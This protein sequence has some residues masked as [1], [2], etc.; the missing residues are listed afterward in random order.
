MP[1]ETAVA[2]IKAHGGEYVSAMSGK[3]TRLLAGTKLEDGRPVE[4]SSKYQDFIKRCAEGKADLVKFT[5]GEFREFLANSLPKKKEEPVTSP[6]AAA[7][8]AA[9][10]AGSSFV[11]P[12][13][14]TGGAGSAAS[15]SSSSSSG[16]AANAAAAEASSSAGAAAVDSSSSLWVDRYKPR[17]FQDLAGNPKGVQALDVWLTQWEAKHLK[18]KDEGG[19]DDSDDEEGGAGAGGKK[20]KA[21]GPP[22]PKGVFDF[23]TREASGGPDARAALISGPPG[24]GKT[25]TAILLAKRHGYEVME[26]NASDTRTKK[27]LDEVLKGALDSNVLRFDSAFGG[28]PASQ[29]ATSKR[30]LVVMDEVDGMGI[31]DRGGNAEIAKFL[32]ETKVPI[33]CICNDRQKNSVKT[34]A[35][36][37]YD[38]KF[39]P[40]SIE[41]VK[42]RLRVVTQAEGMT[43]DDTALTQLIESVNGDLRQ[44]LN[45]LHMWALTEKTMSSTGFSAR[46]GAL[47]KDWLHRYDA[48]SAYPRLFNTQNNKLWERDELFFVDY[49]M[50][51]FLIQQAYPTVLES[52]KVLNENV[53]L[54]RMAASA[55]AVSE[56]DIYYDYL[57]SKQAWQLLPSCAMANIRA[58]GFAAGGTCPYI[59]FPAYWGKMSSRT[60]RAR[61]LAELGSHMNSKISGGRSAV[62][63]DYLSPLKH[64]FFTPL[65]RTANGG[66]TNAITKGVADLLDEYNLT[67]EDLMVTLGEELIFKPDQLGLPMNA[68]AEPEFSDFLKAIPAQTKAAFTRMWNS[69]PHRTQVY[70]GLAPGK[71]SAFLGKKV[72][73][74]GGGGGGVALD[75]DGLPIEEDDDGD[76]DEYGGYGS[77]GDN[78]GDDGE[79][80]SQAGDDSDKEVEAMRKAAGVAGKKGR[81]GGAGSR[82]G[83][84]GASTRGRGGATR[85]GGA[86][87]AKKPAAAKKP[88]GGAA[89][90]P[91]AKKKKRSDDSDDEESFDDHVT[92]ED[93]SHPEDIELLDDDDD[94]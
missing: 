16:A 30:R 76:S 74:R 87:G 91:A 14:A 72:K 35:K 65:V 51:P 18:P 47:S 5:E 10:S 88:A 32:R 31:S 81:G 84:G 52:N 58:A 61:L 26:L 85:G 6:A 36:Y 27:A 66:D 7:S 59:P 42:K 62:R 29:A 60:K 23:R 83:R 22:K 78:K 94:D 12:S 25:T 8:A 90:K 49:D 63:L 43:I 11:S 4:Q 68:R 75:A 21:A 82:G 15:F 54:T 2:C 28:G 45:T 57:R 46:K 67:R 53:K 38:I 39:T 20:K 55:A 40:P 93:E 41:D 92:S 80:G 24:I 64:R 71:T 69:M 79:E 86:A 9:S 1:R 44:A 13:F 3:V 17:T 19:D 33:I 50:I 70:G 73:S 34:L 56:G 89:K 37:C 77:G 48:H